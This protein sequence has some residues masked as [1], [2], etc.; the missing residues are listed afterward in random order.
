MARVI[1]ISGATSGI[2]KAIA[3]RFVDLGWQVIGLARSQEQLSGLED[4]LGANF[5]GFAVDIKNH[6]D[7]S[8]VFNSIRQ[9]CDTIHLLV[10]NAA[11]FKRDYFTECSAADIDDIIDTN[12]KGAMYCTLN[13][14]QLMKANATP[15]RIINIGSVAG[16]HGIEKQAIYCAS[17]YGLNGF[18]EA[19]NQ[20]IIRDNISITTLAP[21]GVHTPLWN[22]SNPYPGDIDQ[23]LHPDDIVKLVEYISTLEP[24]IILKN[25]AIFPANEWH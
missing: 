15:G 11:V 1:V 23:I 13:T 5:K 14:V 4:A 9:T 24:R 17:K 12:V 6:A 3:R 19:L 22:D 25:L 8:R 18:A 21:G 2:G 10:N 16:L 7:V 20:E